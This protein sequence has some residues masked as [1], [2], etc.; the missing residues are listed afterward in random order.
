MDKIK[1]M[2]LIALLISQALVL[3]YIEGFFP[4][5]LPGVKLG[6]A[7]IITLV[8]IALFGFKEAIAVVVIRSVLGP[9]LGGSPTSIL[10][11][12]AGGILSTII[13]AVLYNKYSKYFSLIG[14]STA[15]AVFHNIGQLLVASWV[16]G[17]IS[18][19]YTYLPILMIAAAVAGYFIGL[20]SHYILRFLPTYFFKPEKNRTKKNKTK[21]N[22]AKKG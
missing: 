1:K 15:G 8:T 2:V 7:N 22:K 5:L 19:L 3:H 12:L 13:M 6:L 9:I 17:T 16:F 11:S 10:Y 14:I 21:K 18:I 4:V 20:A